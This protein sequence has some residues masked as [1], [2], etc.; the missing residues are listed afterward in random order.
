VDAW[1]LS[2]SISQHIQVKNNIAYAGCV[3]INI[4][5]S[6]YVVFCM[7]IGTWAM[8][9]NKG[10]FFFTLKYEVESKEMRPSLKN[11]HIIVDQT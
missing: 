3:P 6:K 7:V 4:C 9:G 8:L 5:H 2:A 1:T 10:D 11:I